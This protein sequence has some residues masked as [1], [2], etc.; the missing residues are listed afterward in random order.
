[1][2][3]DLQKC[4]TF[5]HQK[6]EGNNSG[7]ETTHTRSLWMLFWAALQWCDCEITASASLTNSAGRFWN[8]GARP[9]VSITDG[10]HSRLYIRYQQTLDAWDHNIGLTVITF[11]SLDSFIHF[12]SYLSIWFPILILL[13]SLWTCF[14][15]LFILYHSGVCVLIF[16]CTL[17]DRFSAPYC[18]TT[19]TRRSL[20]TSQYPI[21]TRC[22]T[23]NRVPSHAPPLNR[24][25]IAPSATWWRHN[26]QFS[27][28]GVWI[29]MHCDYQDPQW[30][31]IEYVTTLYGRLRYRADQYLRQ[32]FIVPARLSQSCQIWSAGFLLQIWTCLCFCFCQWGPS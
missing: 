3:C 11:I 32:Q 6:N 25:V 26:R 10:Y 5:I 12:S 4:Q 16:W 20:G 9:R 31:I 19:Q 18:I 22:D 24:E 21:T 17:S 7:I 15:H 29:V 27:S 13:K 2:F 1:M 23:H 30:L 28:T 14:V 8:V